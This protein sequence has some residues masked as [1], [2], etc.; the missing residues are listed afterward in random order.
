MRAAKAITTRLERHLEGENLTLT[1]LGV[2]EALLH[3]GPLSQRE[4]GRKVLT[5]AGNMTDLIDKLEARD[6]VRRTRSPVDRRSVRVELTAG[7]RATIE[8]LFPRHAAEIDASMRGLTPEEL[9]DL[10]ALLRKLGLAAATEPRAP[11]LAEAST[12]S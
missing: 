10:S 4:L 6:L 11:V 3:K 1:Q 5:S 9:E 2:L 7:G 12:A 8:E